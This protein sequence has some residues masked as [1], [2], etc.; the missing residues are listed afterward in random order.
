MAA[1]ELDL[2]ELEPPQPWEQVVEQLPRLNQGDWLQLWHHRDPIPLW[3]LLDRLQLQYR[4][5]ARETLS[6]ALAATLGNPPSRARYW[7][8][9]WNPADPV[10][11]EQCLALLSR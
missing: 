8:L 4:C 3:G 10:V 7:V 9:V 5:L 11:A 1:I 6:P 2:S